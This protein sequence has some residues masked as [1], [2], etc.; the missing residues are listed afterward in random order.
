MHFKHLLESHSSHKS[1]C[2]TVVFHR[3]LR[4]TTSLGAPAAHKNC[5]YI[6]RPSGHVAPQG[7]KTLAVFCMFDWYLV[8]IAGSACAKTAC[9]SSPLLYFTK[10]RTPFSTCYFGH[11]TNEAWFS[12]H[13]IFLHFTSKLRISTQ[14]ISSTRHPAKTASSPVSFTSFHS[15]F[16]FSNA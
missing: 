15:S 4:I 10:S 6:S 16:A 12:I 2:H 9:L 13:R 8:G 11:T 5:S 1:Y 14:V 7:I 3:S